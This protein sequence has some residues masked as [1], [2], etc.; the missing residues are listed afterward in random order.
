MLSS[1][2]PEEGCGWAAG[3]WGAMAIGLTGT[4]GLKKR[5]I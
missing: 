3:G 2:P 4:T 5:T 1:E